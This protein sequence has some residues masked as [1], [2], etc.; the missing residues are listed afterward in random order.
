MFAA[1]STA[2]FFPG[3]LNFGLSLQKAMDPQSNCEHPFHSP[4]RLLFIPG[5]A[6]SLH[7]L[8][9]YIGALTLPDLALLE[10]GVKVPVVCFCNVNSKY[11][12]SYMC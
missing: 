8:C 5:T 12:C 11:Y 10:C 1:H 9:V 6:I 7:V 2:F 4:Q 3:P